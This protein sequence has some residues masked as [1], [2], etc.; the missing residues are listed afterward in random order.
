MTL[1]YL[2]NNSMIIY[3]IIPNQWEMR[4]ATTYPETSST[5]C[6][7]LR[8]VSQRLVECMGE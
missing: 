8:A 7:V 1:Q 3:T 6:K 4:Q 5:V 2:D